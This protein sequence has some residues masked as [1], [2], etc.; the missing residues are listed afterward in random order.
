M[1]INHLLEATKGSIRKSERSIETDSI[2]QRNNPSEGGPDSDI[3]LS[4]DLYKFW[5]QSCTPLQ[6][7]RIR[8]FSKLQWEEHQNQSPENRI[9]SQL[10]HHIKRQH[11]VAGC[12]KKWTLELDRLG[13]NIYVELITLTL[14]VSHFALQQPYVIS[15]TRTHFHF[16]DEETN[17][18]IK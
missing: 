9:Q 10:C 17:T 18:K 3:N 11:W 13:P 4:G 2:S 8:V 6:P 12:S 16:I 7:K 5:D 15:G 1:D 14:K